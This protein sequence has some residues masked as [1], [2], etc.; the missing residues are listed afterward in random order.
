MSKDRKA[1]AVAAATIPSREVT[2]GTKTTMQVLIAPEA[3]PN[4]AMRCFTIEAG[5]GMPKHTNTVEHEQYV[6]EGSAEVGIDDDIHIV[7]T[8]D[9]VFIPAGHP[10]WYKAL[11]D[12]SFKFL[13]LV[14][15]EQDTIALCLDDAE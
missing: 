1:I 11:G 10:H 2:A 6:L 15:N 3:A 8:G 7:K 5:G 13:C 9:V 14:P 4:F 12:T